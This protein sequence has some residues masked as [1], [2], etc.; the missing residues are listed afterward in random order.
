MAVAIF[1]GPGGLVWAN[2]QYIL[3]AG[4]DDA[5]LGRDGPVGDSG[6]RLPDASFRRAIQA[7]LRGEPPVMVRAVR[8]GRRDR[9]GGGLVDAQVRALPTGPGGPPRAVVILHDVTEDVRERERARLFYASFLSSTNAIEVTDRAGVLVD[10]NPAFERI[11]GYSRSEC[12]GQKPS[13]VQ[14]TKTP[15][16]LYVRMWEDLGNPLKGSW[17]GEILNRDREGRERPVFL[18]ITAV[19][20]ESGAATHYVG[21]AVDLTEQR[22]WERRVAHTDKLASIGQLA[23]GVAH[24]INTPLANIMLIAEGLR[25]RSPDPPTL[26][27]VDAIAEQARIAAEIVRGL[28]DFAR[29]SE[30]RVRDLDLVAV[31]RDTVAFLRGKQP[32]DVNVEERYPAEPV[33]IAGDRSQLVQVLTNILNNAYEALGR[34]GRIVVEVRRVHERAEVEVIDSGPGIPEEALPHIFEPFF[35]TKMEGKGTG[36]GLAICHGIVEAHRGTIRV[37][38]VPGAGASFTVSLPIETSAVGSKR[39]P[40]GDAAPGP[41]A[42]AE[43]E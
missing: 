17:S 23:A 8:T 33:P 30:P 11:Y 43:E 7:A 34:T 42:E 5:L 20:D 40:E 37:R 41:E 18:T 13:L 38:N 4:G 35:T 39:R 27:R 31:A 9:P 16:E 1:E 10:V 2:G 26:G 21:V 14:S 12:I 19:R 25:R 36:L 29:R 22:S 32:A 28:L 6:V 24:E 3:E 15:H